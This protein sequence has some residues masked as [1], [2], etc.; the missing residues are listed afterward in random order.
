M[1]SAP[2]ERI[3][4]NLQPLSAHKG[5]ISQNC[6]YTKPLDDVCCQITRKIKPIWSLFFF[7]DFDLAFVLSLSSSIA[8][9]E[10]MAKELKRLDNLIP[11]LL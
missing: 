9:I 10:E 4:A 1:N 6:K 11:V 2:H 7:F 8:G 5:Y 3:L